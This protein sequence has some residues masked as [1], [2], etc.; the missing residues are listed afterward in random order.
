MKKNVA[1][2][3]E[4]C[5]YLKGVRRKTVLVQALRAGVLLLILD[6]SLSLFCVGIGGEGFPFLPLHTVF[7]CD[8]VYD[9]ISVAPF[10]NRSHISTSLNFLRQAKRQ[11]ST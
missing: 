5:L 4:H 10:Y 3:P 8:I 9:R 7:I 6:L 11:N 2:S 1:C